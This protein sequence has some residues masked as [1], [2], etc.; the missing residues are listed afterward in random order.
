MPK[1]EKTGVFGAKNVAETFTEATGA[2]FSRAGTRGCECAR[3]VGARAMTDDRARNGVGYGCEVIWVA[4]LGVLVF[5][6]C[7]RGESGEKA[8][9]TYVFSRFG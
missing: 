3:F 1:E 9:A 6:V 2:V 4:V 7:G 5:G 8:N